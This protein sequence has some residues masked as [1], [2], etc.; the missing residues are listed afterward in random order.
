MGI[1]FE[2]KATEETRFAAFE[3]LTDCTVKGEIRFTHP[4][5]GGRDIKALAAKTGALLSEF[6][7]TGASI[8]LLEGMIAVKELTSV[9]N[10]ERRTICS[11]HLKMLDADGADVAEMHTSGEAICS[12]H[13]QF[14][15]EI[16][17]RTS[18]DDALDNVAIGRPL[19]KEIWQAYFNRQRGLNNEST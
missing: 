9:L 12:K 1:R 11:I 7:T 10:F 5:Y 19:K 2:I 18:L 4:R 13:D 3:C 16:G 6:A 15:Y 17:R 14:C 8:K